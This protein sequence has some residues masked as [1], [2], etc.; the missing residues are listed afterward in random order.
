MNRIFLTILVLFS[1]NLCSIAQVAGV[2]IDSKT[3]KPL[4][5]VNVYY[6]NGRGFGCYT[7]ERG[8]FIL[9]EDSTWRELTISTMG[10][11][12]QVVHLSPFGK[13]KNLY[14]RLKP[15]GSNLKEVTITQKKTKYSRKNNPAVELMKRVIANKRNHD[16]HSKDFFSY[17]SYEKMTASVNNVTDRLFE[18]EE[19]KAWA[20]LKDHVERHPITDKLIL[21]LTVDE[22]LSHTFYRKSPKTEKELIKAKTSKGVNELVSMGDIINTFLKDCFTDVNIYDEECRLLQL[23]FKSPI[24]NSAISFYRFY[25]QDTIAV[26]PKDSAII[27]GFTPNNQQDI[28]FTGQLVIHKDS[29]WQVLRSELYIPKQA[30]VNFIENIYINQDYEELPSGERV[31]T[32]NDMMVEL[33]VTSWLSQLMVQR[34]VR[35]FDYTF[36]PIEPN[37]FKRIKG[38]TFQEPDA[39]MHTEDSYWQQYRKEKLTDAESQMGGFLN[40]LTQMKGFKPVMF[41]VKA[42]IGNYIETSDSTE[43]N[44]FDIGPINTIISHNHYDKWRFRLSGYSTAHL[45]PHLFFGGYIAYGTHSKNVYGMGELVYSINKKAYLTREFPKN[46]IHLSYRRDVTA[47]FEKFV[48]TDKD[49][50]FLALKASSVNQY[51]LIS[52]WKLM[53]DREWYNGVKAQLRFTRT[54]MRPVDKLFYQPLGT[55]AAVAASGNMADLQE[56]PDN[57]VKSI[58]LTEFYASASFEPGATFINTK[59]RRIKINKDAPLFTVSHTMGVKGFLGGDYNYNVTEAGLYKRFYIPAGWG[60]TDFDVKAGIQ[61]NKVPFPLLIHPAANQSYILEDFTFNLISNYEF[62][63]DRYV[64]LMWNWD[65]CGKILNRIPLIKKLKW[66]EH[67]GLNV[68]WGTLSDK[69]N[70]AKSGFNDSDLFYFPGHFRENDD[71]SLFYENNTVVMNPKIPYVELRVGIHNIFKLFHIEYVRRLTYKNNPGTHK[72]GVRFMFRVMF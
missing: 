21:P 42:L 17:T 12:K 8:R 18:M 44:K 20:F 65:L 40:E 7:D 30:N 28:G 16:L 52:E 48:N 57:Y 3:R 26:A 67:L 39:T 4:E 58:N 25:I 29:T 27:V 24:A 51:N 63:N 70:P 13:N 6:D 11:E 55:D 36:D 14:V 64:Q 33:K 5:Y 49:N 22:Q 45:N 38:T 59:Q 46:N 31:C 69:N 15:E 60:Y 56:T 72:N 2:V 23:H 62:L 53:W 35:N 9:K 37:V 66:R 54:N 32:V 43:T 61:W 71:G 1:V 10:Y 68:L 34:T 41:V 50:M 47:P 19:G